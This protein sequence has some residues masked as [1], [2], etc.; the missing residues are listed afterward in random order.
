LVEGIRSKKESISV[1]SDKQRNTRRKRVKSAQLPDKDP[2]RAFVKA[3]VAPQPK[4][5]KFSKL[6]A[7]A[8][9]QAT[10]SSTSNDIFSASE[11]SQQRVVPVQCVAVQSAFASAVLGAL[12]QAIAEGFEDY[13]EAAPTAVPGAAFY[14]Y[15]YITNILYSYIANITPNMTAVPQWLDTLGCALLPQEATL[16]QGRVSY[17]FQVDS[18]FPATLPAVVPGTNSLVNFYLYKNDPNI[19]VDMFSTQVV[20]ATY[21]ELLGQQSWNL[22]LSFA[23]NSL[24]NPSWAMVTP[25]S[26]WAVKDVTAFAVSFQ[27]LGAQSN[28]VGSPL[29]EIDFETPITCPVFAAFA[30]YDAN[31]NVRYFRHGKPFAGDANF[32]GYIVAHTANKQE[33]KTKII[34]KFK[35]IDFFEFVD[36]F[37]LYLGKALQKWYHNTT[38]SQLA[39][40]TPPVWPLTWLQTCILL[41]QA[42]GACW[43][44]EILAGQFMSV[45]SNVVSVQFAP[46]TWGTNCYPS[47]TINGLT[48]P[49]IFLEAMRSLQGVH[50][51][52]TFVR[53]GKTKKGGVAHIFPL[54]GAFVADSPPEQYEYES[55]EG[56]F[57]PVFTVDPLETPL[58]LAD[59]TT[60]A[61]DVVNV[62]SSQQNTLIQVWND[63]M[64]NL[65]SNSCAFESL[66]SDKPPRALHSIHQTNFCGL[67]GNDGKTKVYKGSRKAPHLPVRTG[68]RL[69]SLS[70]TDERKKVEV[71]VIPDPYN[72]YGAIATT[73][74]SEII[75]AVWSNW[76]NMIILPQVRVQT[77][78]TDTLTPSSY[79][80]YAVGFNEPYMLLTSV[81]DGI[82][83]PNPIETLSGR[84]DRFATSMIRNVMSDKSSLEEFLCNEAKAG[85]GG[86][87]G[88]IFGGIAGGLLEKWIPGAGQMGMSLGSLLPV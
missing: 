72:F 58:N 16:V 13:A 77:Q 25:R 23:S 62:N 11:P 61:G 87:L 41:R 38:Q 12:Q 39:P 68:R 40:A 76:Q 55:S 65:K 42:L 8:K 28:G 73:S 33:I 3:K 7:A 18:G 49:I 43:A 6:A 50:V 15:V 88:S 17:S 10:P 57:S 69:R 74:Q 85:R 86:S 84:H 27:Q 34:P 19:L 56:V 67:I 54:L 51:D 71:E 30:S 53:N 22:L 75:K 4:G 21:T 59:C 45:E 14:A 24:I 2:K 81:G 82:S 47:K 66:G 26:S 46:F 20:P 5:A 44:P 63:F 9:R 78:Q 36:V 37:S 80:D 83:Q 1:M 64:N 79:L 29:T 32:C 31:S 48:L 60:A 52:V 35:Q 70:L